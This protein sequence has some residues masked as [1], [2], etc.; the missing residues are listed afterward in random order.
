MNAEQRGYRGFFI[1]A[2]LAGHVW[3][4]VRIMNRGVKSRSRASGIS[5]GFLF[6]TLFHAAVAAVFL[7]GPF[8]GKPVFNLPRDH[9]IVDVMLVTLGGRDIPGSGPGAGGNASPPWGGDS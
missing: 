3:F 8:L 2:L 1:A 7:L 5:L 4:R 9:E 6:S